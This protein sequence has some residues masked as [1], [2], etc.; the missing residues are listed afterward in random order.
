MPSSPLSIR[1][2]LLNSSLLAVLGG[3][4]LLL[5][6]NGWIASQERRTA[7]QALATNVR[8]V[9]QQRSRPGEGARQLSRRMQGLITPNLLV[10]LEVQPG[11]PFRPPLVIGR[12]PLPQGFTVARLLPRSGQE[13]LPPE[14][15]RPFAAGARQYLTSSLPIQSGGQV[16]QLR[17]L[18][19]ITAKIH[20][21]RRSSLLLTLAAGV[22][23]LFTSLLLRPAL[24]RGLA[25][26]RDLGRSMVATPSE[27]LN[28]QR[29]LVQ[30]QPQE[31]APIALAF[32]DLLDRLSASWERQRSFVNGVSHE[33]RSPITVIGSYAGRLRRRSLH[34][35]DSDREDLVLIETEADRMAR[36]VADL[37]DLARL[38]AQ[39]LVPR[40]IAFPL[41]PLLQ[42]V[43]QRFQ[44]RC[45]GRLL[46]EGW[47][48]D[49]GDG[50]WAYGDPQQLE[51]CLINLI[52]NAHKYAPAPSPIRLS[53]SAGEA[54]GELQ[55]V[56]HVIDA[57]PGVP[58]AE[59]ERIFERFSRG[60]RTASIPGSGIG[61]AVVQSLMA[62]MGGQ[63]LV[64]DGP[65]GVGSDF[66]LRLP[67][68]APPPA[69]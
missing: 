21:Q 10:W 59:R 57:G 41:E 45:D 17:L 67:A 35:S 33:L 9:L 40:R 37:L 54:G 18:E 65:G 34:L 8:G 6:A 3:Y 52:E 15:P 14:R 51:H 42:A 31:L 32:N 30:P 38:D 20:Q 50:L 62:A 63:V 61:L 44:G 5:A 56:L 1:R 49:P 13:P 68:A 4:G 66:Q 26:L 69:A 36:L 23:S 28:Q 64:V 24:S 39:R 11:V 22:S 46:L 53:V 7:H 48:E 27:T 19:D 25:P 58:E 16:L 47:A 60:S 12:F 55:A 2:R 43:V 29:L